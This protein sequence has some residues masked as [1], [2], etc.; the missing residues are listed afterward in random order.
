MILTNRENLSNYRSL[1]P[2]FAMA[3]DALEQLA[4]KPFK[5]GRYHVDGENVFIN[6]LE[7]DTHSEENA[8]MEAHRSYID[9]MWMVSGE[10]QIG[11]CPV[12]CMADITTP[13]DSAGDAALSKVP[14]GCSYVQMKP[15][16]VCVLFP[17]DGHAPGMNVDRCSCV[18][19]LI[20]KVRV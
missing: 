11:V 14:Q 12:T 2:Y 18:Q 15:G 1:N 9:V 13:Y 20:A 4:E 17:E 8:L 6:A 16:S 19:K 3:F 7:Y 10:E 5:K